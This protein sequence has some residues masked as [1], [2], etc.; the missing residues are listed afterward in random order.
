M[1]VIIIVIIILKKRILEAAITEK[2][3]IYCQLNCPTSRIPWNVFLVPH[4]SKKFQLRFTFLSIPASKPTKAV[5]KQ[6]LPGYG[7]NNPKVSQNTYF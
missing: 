6:N 1:V 5:I 2:E 4:P 3:F 7:W